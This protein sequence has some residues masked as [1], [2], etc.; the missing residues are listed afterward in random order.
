MPQV[1]GDSFPEFTA[2]DVLSSKLWQPRPDRPPLG[3]DLA[4]TKIAVDF[5]N[6]AQRGAEI[7]VRLG[8]PDR[9]HRE[10]AQHG[11]IELG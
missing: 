7:L 1:Q 4:C 10:T 6:V 3:I 9:L 5:Q 11:D 8:Q 2:S